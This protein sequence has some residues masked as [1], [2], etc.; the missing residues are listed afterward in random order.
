MPPAHA[1]RFLSRSEIELLKRWIEQ[2][3]KFEP[4]W[5]FQPINK[6]D[7]DRTNLHQELSDLDALILKKIKENNSDFN[8]QA[9]SLTLL[10]RI[11]FDLTGIGPT[12][13]EIAF[14]IN[15]PDTNIYENLIDSLLSTDRYAERMTTDWLDVARYAD[16]Q[17]MHSDGW[18]SMYPWRD[19]VINAFKKNMPFDQ[20]ILQQLAGDLLPD[21]TR[22]QLIATGFNRNHET[23]AEGGVV[24][25]EFR[26]EYAHDRVKTTS[27]AFLGMTMECARCHDHKYDPISQKEYYQMFAF[28]DQVDEVGLTG[29]DGNSGPNLLL[30]DL[31]TQNRIDSIDRW[32]RL[33]QSEINNTQA[34]W[35]IKRIPTVAPELSFQ[36]K[37]VL[38]LDCQKIES[39]ILDGQ[40]N[41]S[42]SGQVEI[43]HSDRGNV[44]FL[45]D[46]YEYISVRNVGLF[47][48]YEPFS[49]A[50]W[51]NPYAQRTSQTLLG[52][53]GAK[54][55][56]WRGW[57]FI[58]DSLNRPKL[59]LINALPHDA[60]IV[61]ARQRIDVNDWSHL[62]F[63]YD[64]SGKA[65]GVRIFINGKEAEIEIVRDA[66]QRSIY[67]IAFNKEKT[68]TPLRIGKS[69]RAF[70]GEYG[71][72][73]GLLDDI[74]L[75]ERKLS[76]LEIM[77]LFDK[78]LVAKEFS[79]QVRNENRMRSL[80][81]EHH[82]VLH[83]HQG[84][85]QLWQ[86][87]QEKMELFVQSAEVMI[88]EDRKDQQPTH[89]LIRGNYDHRGEPVEASTPSAILPYPDSFP[90]NRLGLAKW[91]IA[92]ENPLTARVIAN[93]LWQQ[94]FGKGLVESA[95][96]FGLQGQLPTHPEVLDYLAEQLINGGWDIKKIIKLIV[97]SKTYKQSSEV[98]REKYEID[99]ENLWYA[100][101][102][103]HRL[104]AEMIRD[105]V[106]QS[107]F[108]L[109]TTL[110]GP[111]VK[112]WQP[113]GLWKE[114]TSS[115][116][117]LRAYEPD[118]GSARYR[119][120]LYTFVRRTSMHPMMEIFDAPTRSVCTVKRQSTETPQQALVLL[121]D[122]QFI[123]ASRMLAENMCEKFAN[124]GDRISQAYLRICSGEIQESKLLHLLDF[125]QQEKDRFHHN[126]A[127]ADAYT[128]I[129]QYD[130]NFQGDKADLAATTLVINTII[131][132]DDFYLKR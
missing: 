2:G 132:L 76:S 33:K 30:P 18:R 26:K 5:A 93:R 112:P 46:E 64:G 86:L 63:I 62:A 90:K 114:K 68:R 71:I 88:M 98:T 48:H 14:F 113:E 120:S 99:P 45:D 87:R 82:F 22:A 9:D 8:A 84:E 115:T 67:P 126:P 52:N 27:A 37:R 1:G 103:S 34:N 54:G 4:H 31:I 94:F 107:A 91:I 38:F 83:P 13:E 110:G 100:R 11:Y 101:G 35:N 117:L 128:S 42:V 7:P 72:F 40:K 74:M 49:A 111:S 73:K 44:I 20:F 66:L 123:E 116:H 75:F 77:A 105:H 79:S 29:D 121:N 130:S 23:T 41:T 16:S 89:V 58:L 95:H 51:V 92:R 70:T 81:S 24:D 57:D 102:P 28:F 61:Q 36:Q 3:A 122:Q 21:P 118:S 131:N 6:L 78:N 108:L 85:K 55:V 97:L 127:N 32:I 129:G 109:D 65:D 124:P 69:Y 56:F 25:E 53:S 106:L 59:R 50:L 119:R 47:D 17:G 125:Y 80:L 19:W 96:D 43:S 10:R 104:T 39:G 12:P 15:N 60:L